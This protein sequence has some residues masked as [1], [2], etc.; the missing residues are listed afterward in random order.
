MKAEERSEKARAAW[1]RHRAERARLGLPTMGT[2]M[3]RIF[4]EDVE[5]LRAF[6]VKGPMAVHTLIR[7]ASLL[8]WSKWDWMRD[9]RVASMPTAENPA[10][11]PRRSRLPGPPME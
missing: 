3:I 9:C 8:N 5:V 11:L 10:G 4:R 1:A 2:T 6:A 7:A